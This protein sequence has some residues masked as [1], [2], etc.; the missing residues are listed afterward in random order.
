VPYLKNT[1]CVEVDWIQQTQDRVEW[2]AVLKTV[3]NWPASQERPRFMQLVVIVFD[4][5][6][7]GNH[8]SVKTLLTLA[9]GRRFLSA[10]P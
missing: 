4:L 5:Q 3:M 9:E 6:T 1:G 8:E 7:T 2:R 10:R